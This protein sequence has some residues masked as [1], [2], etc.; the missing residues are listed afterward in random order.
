V[1]DTFP[2]RYLG[3]RRAGLRAKLGLGAGAGE[4]DDALGDDLL[5]LLRDGQVDMTS[6]FR[7][8]S[9]V[10]RGDAEP[11][12]ALF[13][14]PAAFDAWTARWE[15][16]RGA[17]GA[18]AGDVAAA[19]DAVNPVYVPR[20]QLVEEALTAA[21]AGDLAPV[22][23]LIDVLDRPYEERPGLERYAAPAPPEFGAYR[24]FCGT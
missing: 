12:R 3:H 17:R 13:P 8:L 2:A 20:N 6:A 7:A 14:D 4:E 19:M 24:T 23:R 10:V 1:L 21:T 22:Q 9:S 5:A 11:A 15:A 16:R 18:D